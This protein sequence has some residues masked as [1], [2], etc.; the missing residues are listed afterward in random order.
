MYIIELYGLTQYLTN[1][2]EFCLN[3]AKIFLNDELFSSF[4]L[5]GF[6]L[7]SGYILTA[8]MVNWE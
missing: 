6:V 2:T 7:F 5:Y 3:D 4:Y 8:V 1:E